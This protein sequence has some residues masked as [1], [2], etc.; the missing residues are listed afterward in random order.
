M[1]AV[2]FV[3]NTE[4]LK[5]HFVSCQSSG[6]I[7]EYIVNKPEFLQNSDIINTAFLI[8]GLIVH[9]L[10]KRQKDTEKTLNDLNRNIQRN[11]YKKG[12]K[13]EAG[14]INQSD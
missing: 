8:N 12:K 6:F 1:R 11:W 4:M 5:N 2:T 9:L 13:Q 7:S 10:I 3:I 14:K